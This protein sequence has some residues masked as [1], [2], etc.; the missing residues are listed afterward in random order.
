MYTVN[1]WPIIVAAVVSFA[2]GALWYSPILFG[3]EWMALTKISE[4]DMAAAKAKGVWKSYIVHFIAN[5]IS[6]A[7]LGFIIVAVGVQSG[8]DGAFFGF[9]VW[10]G[11]TLPL[12][13]SHLLWQ[14]APMKLILID[15]VQV[16]IGLVIGGAIIGAWR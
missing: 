11:F 15:T 8:S 16:L 1:I 2:I 5:L 6:F 7:V 9:L 14:K 12:H 4:A 10:L 3:K 13:I